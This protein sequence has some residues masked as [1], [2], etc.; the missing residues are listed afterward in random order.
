MIF[1]KFSDI[2]VSWTSEPTNIVATNQDRS[3]HPISTKEIF[4]LYSILIFL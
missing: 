1:Y 2:K 3:A 4:I